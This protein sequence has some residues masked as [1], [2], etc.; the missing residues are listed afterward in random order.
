LFR[1]S[2]AWS[3]YTFS[4]R[5]AAQ[6]DDVADLH[7]FAVDHDSVDQELDQRAALIEACVF[8]TGTDRLAEVFDARSHSLQM[9]ALH[10]FGIEHVLFACE[11][12][13]ARF[14]QRAPLLQFLKS[15][16]LRLVRVHQPRDTTL[17]LS[18]APSEVAPLCLALFATQPT[19]TKSL[20]GILQDVRFAEQLAEV[21]PH[22]SVD[23]CGGY[24]ASVAGLAAA[25]HDQ[26]VHALAA[27]VR[28]A[29]IVPDVHRQ[30]TPAAAEQAS[31][32]VLTT[33]VAAR[34][35]LVAL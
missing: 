9:L 20:H 33:C 15:E 25:A 26:H 19:I 28:V 8:E 35:L 22:Q 29:S 10:G 11:L 27:V 6:R 31:E 24:L 16:C 14:E 4:T 32:K 5:E 3:Q 21:M 34:P 7:V 17:E 1:R 23:T 18:A 13:D 12:G 2:I 30:A